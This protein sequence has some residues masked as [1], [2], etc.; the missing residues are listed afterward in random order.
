MSKLF[1]GRYSFSAGLCQSG[2]LEHYDRY[3]QETNWN[4]RATIH[5]TL[6]VLETIP[7]ISQLC[8]AIE[9]LAS[10]IFSQQQQTSSSKLE[11]KGPA[12]SFA[13][14]EVGNPTTILGTKTQYTDGEVEN[15]RQ[16]CTFQALT[17]LKYFLAD[18]KINEAR[19]DR[20]IEEALTTFQ[21]RTAQNSLETRQAN[22]RRYMQ[23]NNID[24]EIINNF[25]EA[26]PGEPTLANLM[27]ISNIFP[28]GNAKTHIRVLSNILLGASLTP[29]EAAQS[30]KNDFSSI[31]DGCRLIFLGN[32]LFTP[33]EEGQGLVL[34]GGNVTV[35]FAKKDNLFVVYD[36]HGNSG[37]NNGK[38]AAFA[39]VF[40]TNVEAKEFLSTIVFRS[41]TSQVDTLT[42]QPKK[43]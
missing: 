6:Y 35:A 41:D 2:R 26:V 27:S 10:T 12:N 30:Y 14:P 31:E 1:L 28:G 38:F 39:K 24:A 22:A 40:A 42:V 37:I 23:E 8:Y 4:C 13:P 9:A 32:D 20:C 36:S 5:L 33:P 16:S 11:E 43:S 15:D 29:K 3:A 18:G 25:F 17:F 7:F 19:I 34:T 21:A